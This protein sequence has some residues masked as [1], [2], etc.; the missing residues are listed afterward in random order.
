MSVKVGMKSKEINVG[1]VVD[2]QTMAVKVV[3][4]EAYPLASAQVLGVSRVAV[5]EE[6]WQSWLRN[7][8]GVITFSVRLLSATL[9]SYANVYSQNGSIID[10]LSAWRKN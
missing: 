2:E 3:L 4:P 5:K 7:C 9:S 6:K 1:Y 10:G 8:Q